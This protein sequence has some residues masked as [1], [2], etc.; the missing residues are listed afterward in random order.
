VKATP[1]QPVATA[2]PPATPDLPLVS[3][4]DEARKLPPGTRFRNPQGEILTVP[5]G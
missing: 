4:P 5:N 3:T 1:P 2:A